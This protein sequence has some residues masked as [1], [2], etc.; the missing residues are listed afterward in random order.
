MDILVLGGTS[1]VGRW[2][3]EDLLARGHDLTLFT[4]GVTGPDLFPGVPRLVG[5]RATGEY[6]ELGARD[7]VVDVSA[8]V[9]RHLAQAAQALGP[10]GRYLLISTV[11]VYDAQRA[12]GEITEESHATGTRPGHRGHRRRHLRRAQ[13]G[14]RGRPRGPLRRPGDRRA[15][16]HRGGTAR[17]DRPLHLLGPTRPR[18]RPGRRP[19]STGPARAGGGRA[20]PGRSGHAAAGAGPARHVQRHGTGARGEPG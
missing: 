3:V 6:G 17:P 16:G 8:Y 20:G 19:R 18:G 2:I 4:R 12:G 5:D 1:F 15:A 11:S 13:G 14:V 7:A 9:P 10:V